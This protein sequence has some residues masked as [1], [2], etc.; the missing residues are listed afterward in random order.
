VRELLVATANPH[1]L[2]EMRELLEGTGLRVMGLG[3]FPGLSAAEET[4]ATFE[5]NAAIKAEAAA[6]ATGL[7]ALADDSGLLVDALGGAPGVLS[8]RYAGPECDSSANN[9]RLL[10]EL[11]HVPRE[12]RTATFV[13]TIAV[14]ADGRQTRFFR[15]ECRGEILESPRGEG[16]FGYDPLFYSPELGRTFAEAAGEK[17]RVSHRAR[18]LAAF[19]EAVRTGSFD[20]WF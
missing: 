19:R 5:E 1:K 15:G 20:D 3:E 10:R 13:C 17:Q 6:R 9:A 8:A 11:A 2:A 16:G 7:V 14:A 4:G 12:R 18:A